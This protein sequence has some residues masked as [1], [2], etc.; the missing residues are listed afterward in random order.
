MHR[1][2]LVI[3]VAAIAVACVAASPV[4]AARPAKRGRYLGPTT[5]LCELNSGVVIRCPIEIQVSRTRRSAIVG[6]AQAFHC[7]GGIALQR[8]DLFSSRVTGR[9]RIGG[10]SQFNDDIPDESSLGPGNLSGSFS[11]RFS[12][13]FRSSRRSTGSGQGHLIVRDEYGA[14]VAECDTGRWTYSARRIR[15]ASSISR[16]AVAGDVESMLRGSSGWVRR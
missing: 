13:R 9:G 8:V 3:A 15:N 1:R 11:Q 16:A 10:T 4:L 5:Q 6:F 12:G 2:L 7:P 14:P